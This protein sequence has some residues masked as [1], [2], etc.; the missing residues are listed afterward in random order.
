M[1]GRCLFTLALIEV[2]FVATEANAFWKGIGKMSG[3]G[4]FWG[5]DLI[6]PFEPGVPYISRQ[7]LENEQNVHTL[8]DFFYHFD[9]DNVKVPV[10]KTR[11]EELVEDER[12]VIRIGQRLNH[13]GLKKWP[14]T[15]IENDARSAKF[16]EQFLEAFAGRKAGVV[17]VPTDEVYVQLALLQFYDEWAADVNS[18]IGRKARFFGFSCLGLCT[19]QKM[20]RLSKGD[21]PEM[22]EMG[23]F[24]LTFSLG[25]QQSWENDLSYPA[26]Y[27]GSR[28]VRWLSFYPS[29]EW[30]FGLT[31]GQAVNFFVNAGPA[32]HYFW[33]EAFDVFPRVSA[34]GRAGVRF[35]RISV[36]AQVDRFFPRI[37][38]TEFG[39][40][41][42]RDHDIGY[43]FF[44]GWEFPSALWNR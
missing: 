21:S 41:D 1:R 10:F 30:R 40:T 5:F 35:W 13:D 17:S 2:M 34:R 20:L 8:N 9:E 7:M 29:L 42:P 25:Y 23:K 44:F 16:K 24:L 39:S 6:L 3:P 18:E 32:L 19:S 4:P 31:Q 11:I 33:G 27:G 28:M 43:G 37:G 36:G 26:S 12:L 14:P 15:E 22:V 38:H